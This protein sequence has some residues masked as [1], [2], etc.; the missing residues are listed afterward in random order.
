M[1]SIGLYR[2]RNQI[3]M[4]GEAQRILEESRVNPSAL[5]LRI[6]LP[7]LEGA[8]LED[9]ENLAAKWAALLASAANPDF[10]NSVYQSFS[11]IMKQLSPK[12]AIVLDLLYEVEQREGEDAGLI[13][14]EIISAA[15]LDLTEYEIITDNLVRLG[16]CE[17]GGYK[18]GDTFMRHL[19]KNKVIGLTRLGSAFISACTPEHSREGQSL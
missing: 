19:D 6:L 12:D 11:E 8:A 7:L 17:T 4:L 14:D 2:L 13:R 5:P 16:L 3:R 10:K 18:F 1:S 15:K 9:H